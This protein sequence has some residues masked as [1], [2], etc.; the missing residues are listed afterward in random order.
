MLK[1][2]IQRTYPDSEIDPNSKSD[3]VVAANGTTGLPGINPC[4]RFRAS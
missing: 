3:L 4:C 2:H 1:L